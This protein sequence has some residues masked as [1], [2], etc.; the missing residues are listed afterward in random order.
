[1]ENDKIISEDYEEAL[2]D[3]FSILSERFKKVWLHPDFIY[4]LTSLKKR[5]E[6]NIQ[7]LQKMTAAVIIIN[8]KP[9]FVKILNIRNLLGRYIFSVCSRN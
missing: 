3:I 2:E 6:Q 9:T 7:I 4:K 5:E 1:M 8:R